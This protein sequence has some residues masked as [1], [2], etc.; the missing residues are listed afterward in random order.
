MTALSIG[1]KTPPRIER[2]RVKNFRA[3]HNFELNSVTPLTVLLGPNGSGKSTILDVFA[4]LAECFQIGLHRAW[5]KRG[6]ARELK[7]RGAMGPVIVEMTYRERTRTPLITYHI[8]VDEQD[9]QP[10]VQSEWL[11]WKLGAQ[12]RSLSFLEYRMGVGSAISG[13]KPREHDKRIQLPLSS[14]D[15]LAGDVLGQFAGHPRV[16]ALRDFITG[17]HL[18]DH[19]SETAPNHTLA[20]PQERLS[21][22]GDNLANVI[23]YLG[24]DHPRKLE[25]LFSQLRD[26]IPR[27]QSATV[28]SMPD[29]RLSLEINDAPFVE[30][31]AAQFASNGTLRLLAFLALLHD[32]KP[33]SLIGLKALENALH[34]RLLGGLAEECREASIASQIL[35]TT[36]SPYFLDALQPEEVRV[37]WREDDGYTRCKSVC[38]IDGVLAFVAEGAKLGDLWMEG[39]FKVGDP[40]ARSTMAV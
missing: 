18:W 25:E 6:G 34:P 5:D 7:T 3:L 27:I 12:G 13:D 11:R 8:A 37:L 15:K 33:P 31:I 19:S 36:H 21:Q 23:K 38:D 39:H 20:G 26:R 2:M 24:D 1:G 10:V 29:G 28:N 30:P 17:W 40:E 22:S 14:P 35:V 32:P 4:F 9:G 16:V